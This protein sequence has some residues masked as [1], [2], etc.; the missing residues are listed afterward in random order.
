M[1]Q[2]SEMDSNFLQQESARTPMHISPVIVYDQSARKGGKVRFKEILTV[3]ERNRPDDT[4]GFGV[5]FSDQT[6]GNLVAADEPTA[7]TILQSFN[8]WDDIDVH[9]RGSVITSGGHGFC[10]IGRREL[11]GILQARASALAYAM[12]LPLAL[13][14][15]PFLM[16]LMAGCLLM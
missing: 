3:F 2:L 14:L 1:Q 7:R 6:L 13:V 15:S 11:L 4:F 5:V 8:H 12:G 10:G 9:Y 16:L